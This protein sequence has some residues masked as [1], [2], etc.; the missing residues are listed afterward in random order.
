MVNH[1]V[2]ELPS[3]PKDNANIDSIV[4]AVDITRNLR[5]AQTFVL[6]KLVR[7]N[8]HINLYWTTGDGLPDFNNTNSEALS[9]FL[10]W[11]AREKNKEEFDKGFE[12]VQT[13]MMHK[14]GYL[15][16]KLDANDNA[17]LDGS[18]IASDADLRTLKALY[19]AS[20]QWKDERYTD[21]ID[22]LAT[23]LEKVAV[24][25]DNYLS[26]YGGMSGDTAWTAREVWLS[27]TDFTVLKRLSTREPWKSVYTNMKQA[28]LD[29]QL[30]NG[31][32]N[33]EL[34]ESRDEGNGL[35]LGEY[36]INSMW[37]MVRAAESDDAELQASARKSLDFYKKKFSTDN[38]VYSSYTSSGEPSFVE[39]AWAYALVA[40]AAIALEDAEFSKDMI[41]K[42]I[43]FQVMDNN[44]VY[45]GA[46]PEG[47]DK[48][49]GQFTMQEAIL[50]MQDF[51]E[52]AYKMR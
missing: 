3:S 7:Q 36:S 44:S 19:I 39:S 46:I 50:T 28:F 33:P 14:S 34:T 32:Y 8:R 26:P 5:S 51:V 45:F 27:Y 23:G 42:L 22:R 12:F 49:V 25:S 43:S 29:A 20:E 35:D 15:M 21:M 13:R 37:M 17:S 48:R 4:E 41:N 2:P 24:T 6:S 52:K 30:D 11:N 31:L 18:N 1:Y 10:L 16:W 40:R 9:Y 38:A 47:A